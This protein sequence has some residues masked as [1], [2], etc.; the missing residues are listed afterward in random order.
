MEWCVKLGSS[1]VG[2][3]RLIVIGDQHDGSL[4][5]CGGITGLFK[6]R[7][8]SLHIPRTQPHLMKKTSAGDTGKPQALQDP[9]VKA[10]LQT[11]RVAQA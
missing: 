8:V 4:C 9:E 5:T 11:Q 6:I 7:S 1:L 2:L 10:K 3:C